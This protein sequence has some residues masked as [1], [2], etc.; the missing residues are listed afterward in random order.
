MISSDHE[1]I[2]KTLDGII[3]SLVGMTMISM[4]SGNETSMDSNSP[5]GILL[6]YYTDIFL[7]ETLLLGILFSSVNYRFLPM[8]IVARGFLL[9][10]GIMYLVGI[11]INM[12]VIAAF[13]V[14]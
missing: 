7:I 1:Q 13:P 11:R 6:N 3:V 2:N 12:A 5:K 10:F 14:Y 9:T 4:V 8:S